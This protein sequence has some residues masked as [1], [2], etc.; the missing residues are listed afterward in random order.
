[1]DHGTPWRED[2][3]PSGYK[4]LSLWLI[5][6]GIRLHGSGIQHPQTQGKIERFHGSLQR[7]WR[8][9]GIPQRHLQAWLD[10][11]R[12]EH[13]YVRPHEALDMRTPASVWAPSAKR[14]DP[15]PPRWKYPTPP[16]FLN[17][18]F[19]STHQPKHP[20]HP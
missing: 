2:Q 15:H 6:Q 18:T 1:M 14:Y 13:N 5:R 12:W 8:R 19:Q 10:E 9:R 7:A 3:A 16:C 17:V 20:T 4:H 11:Y